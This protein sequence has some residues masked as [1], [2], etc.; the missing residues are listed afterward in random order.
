MYRS[1]DSRKLSKSY[2]FV[3]LRV[4]TPFQMNGLIGSTVYK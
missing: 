1:L 4:I 3:A 2:R